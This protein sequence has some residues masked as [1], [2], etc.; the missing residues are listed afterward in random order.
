MSERRVLYV[1]HNHPAIRP[2]GAETYALELYEAMRDRG[3]YVPTLLARSGRPYSATDGPTGIA[4]LDGVGGDPDQ[5][6]LNTELGGWDWFLGISRDKAL[7]TVHLRDFLASVRPDV[8]HF[9]HTLFIGYDA[10]RV[11]RDVL[12]HA[13]IVYTLHEF[14]PIC[15]RRGQLLRTGTEEPCL[16][17][18]PRR[19]HE[20][21][22]GIA[23]E[24]FLLR[25]RFIQSHLSLVD[26]FVAPSA[27]LLERYVDW[28]LPREKLHL[29]EYGRRQ[30]ARPAPAR[31]G[32][33]PNHIGFFG[34]L[35]AHKGV[36]VLMAAMHRLAGAG[37]AAR[38]WLHG[39]NLDLQPND[40][41]REFSA[42]LAACGDSV[43]FAGPYRPEQVP[44]LMA[45]VDWV[46]VPS[47]WWENSPLVIQEAFLHG[48]P[49]ICSHIGGMAE[50]IADGVNGL[51]FQTGDP[52]SLA[53]TIERAVNSPDLWDGLRS[54]IPQVYP[55]DVHVTELGGMYD[56]LLRNELEQPASQA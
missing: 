14:L 41:Q 35:S 34:Q 49:V 6:L 3:P 47:L 16:Q 15:H 27:F 21:F 50:K 20:C 40:F 55:V 52:A 53:E 23:P 17:E 12:P 25:K 19:C 32:G 13:G 43:T 56:K 29:E 2:G 28:G 42:Q 39:A 33:R 54:G 46:V 38:L 36:G 9:Q 4:P 26:R 8:V 24:E 5:Y 22:P 11:V 51:H 10:I 37:S 44:D 31:A 48:R 18:S 1:C 30:V 45:N 7:V